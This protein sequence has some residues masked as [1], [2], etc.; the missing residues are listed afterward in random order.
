M[1][2][3][4][5]YYIY[6]ANRNKDCRFMFVSDEQ[7]NRLLG[8]HLW[9]PYRRHIPCGFRQCVFLSAGGSIEVYTCG[10]QTIPDWRNDSATIGGVCDDNG[11]WSDNRRYERPS[12]GVKRRSENVTVRRVWRRQRRRRQRRPCPGTVVVGDQHTGA[13]CLVLSLRRPLVTYAFPCRRSNGGADSSFSCALA[14][15]LA[16]VSHGDSRCGGSARRRTI[17][18]LS[19]AP[20]YTPTMEPC[21]R[22]ADNFALLS[23]APLSNRR[24]RRR[25]IVFVL[26]RIVIFFLSSTHTANWQ[27]I[28]FD[29]VRS[30]TLRQLLLLIAT[31]GLSLS[32][33]TEVAV[34]CVRS[35]LEYFVCILRSRRIRTLQQVNKICTV[36]LLLLLLLAA[37]HFSHM[38]LSYIEV[39]F[40]TTNIKTLSYCFF[41]VMPRLTNT[42][43]TTLPVTII[44]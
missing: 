38:I 39:T 29:R 30:T 17:L 7:S 5:Q 44:V 22:N 42:L 40:L 13:G 11:A 23:N 25:C 27:L 24:R 15:L 32:S 8:T 1:R 31:C 36:I 43:T 14:V 9:I 34:V 20:C 33:F 18:R 28:T 35:S 6:I 21:D 12:S 19:L 41:Y 16:V 2:F 26:F 4:L 3:N 37:K 10:T